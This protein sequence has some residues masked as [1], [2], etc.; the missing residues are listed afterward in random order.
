GTYGKPYSAARARASA[1]GPAGVK[2]A[3]DVRAG[4]TI[5]FSVSLVLRMLGRRGVRPRRSE[6]QHEGSTM[7]F[8]GIGRCIVDGEVDDQPHA[9][10]MVCDANATHQWIEH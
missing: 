8:E 3:A 9:S 5:A 2:T 6:R 7:R 10:P 4:V 1:P